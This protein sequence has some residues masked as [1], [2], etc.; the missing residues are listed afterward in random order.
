MLQNDKVQ[1][2]NEKRNRIYL[3]K[4]MGAYIYL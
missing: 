1:N 4:K 2:Q 3:K